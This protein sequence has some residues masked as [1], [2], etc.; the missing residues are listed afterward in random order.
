M[1]NKVTQ[2]FMASVCLLLVMTA[3]SLSWLRWGINQHPLYHQWIETQVSQSFGQDLKLSTFQVKLVGPSLELNL[4]GLTTTNGLTLDHLTLGVD[5]IGSIRSSSLLLSGVQAT[6]LAIEVK[7]Q[8]SGSW[9]PT[10]SHVSGSQTPPQLMLALATRVPSLLLDDVS[11]TLTPYQS[12]PIHIPKLDAQVHRVK[13]TGQNTSTVNLSLYSG[14][15]TKSVDDDFKVQLTLDINTHLNT[16]EPTSNVSKASIQRAQI[17]WH[18]NALEVAP[19]LS[20]MV[21]VGSSVDTQSLEI[22]GEYWLDYQTN[23]PV[24]FASKKAH[25]QLLTS[26]EKVDITGNVS[27][28]LQLG[29]SFDKTLAVTDWNMRAQALRGQVNNIDLPL[30]DLQVIKSNHQIVIQSPKLDLEKT[31]KLLSTINTLPVKVSLPMASL[32][33]SGWLREAKLQVDLTQSLEFLF[34]ANMQQVNVNAWAGVP[35]ISHADGDIWLNRYGGKV[36]I[37]DLNGLSLQLPKL[38]QRP[39]QLGGLQG[40]FNW[41]Y[42]ALA[43]RFSSSNM[44]VTLDQGHLNLLMAGTF[45][46]KGSSVEPFIQLALGM[47]DLD[48]SQLPA[49]L[50][51]TMIGEKVGAWISNAAPIGTVTEAALIYN[52]RPGKVSSTVAKMSRVLAIEAHITAPNLSYHPQWPQVKDLVVH[53]AVNHQRVLMQAQ[54]GLVTSGSESVSVAGW[55]VE[56]PISLKSNSVKNSLNSSNE[57][58]KPRFIKVQ[59]HVSGEAEKMM[60]LA[61]QLPLNIKLPSWLHSLKPEGDVSLQG[62]FGIP[63]GHQAQATYDINLTSDN[64]N[65]FWEPLQADVRQVQLEVELSSS[66]EG[67]GAIVGNGLID[68]QYISFKRLSKVELAMPWLPNIPTPILDDVASSVRGR[69]DHITLQ[70]KGRLP[71]HYL[72]TKTNQPWTQEMSGALP[73]VARVSTCM[74]APLECT[75]L[76]AQVDLTKAAITLPAPLSQLQQLQLLGYWQQG[77]QDWY[78]SIDN[79]QVAIQFGPAK[80]SNEWSVTGLNVGFDQPVDW[81]QR[82]QWNF[83]G[84]LDLV[85]MSSWWTVYQNRIKSWVD[86]QDRQNSQPRLP[87]IDVE[88]KRATWFDLD[89]NEAKVR[90]SPLD[91]MEN[92]LAINPWRLDVSSDN[93]IGYIDYFGPQEPLVINVDQAILNFPDPARQTTEIDDVLDD[94]DPTRLID[95]D[96][97]IKKIIKNG[98]PFGQWAFKIRRDSDQVYVHDLDAFIRHS[99]LQ[100][101]LI[102]Q[103]IDGIHYTQ[104]TGRAESNEMANMLMAWGYNPGLTAENSAIEVQLNWPYS[105]LAFTLKDTSGDLGLRLKKGSIS[106]SPNAAQG[107]KVLALFDVSRLIN[108]LQLDFTDIIQPGFSFDSVTAHYS[109]DKGIA[110][111]VTAS[112]FK[113]STLNLT[114][115]GWIDFKRRQVDNN[116]IITLP[117]VDKL[118]LAAL[119]AGLPQLG[120]MIYVVNKLIGDELATFTSARYHVVGSLDKP[121]VKLVRFFDKDYQ[122]QSVKERIENVISIE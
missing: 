4:T 48:L 23:G 61:E 107:L 57:K 41:H 72:T 80:V 34:T 108:R 113:A 18:S 17:Y 13:S 25:I 70:L 2:W 3:V 64:L 73:F 35:K 10:V 46:R 106:S 63:F 32:A 27:A 84:Q 55:Q 104:F 30:S 52:G 91:L 26:T 8:E 90:L 67:V 112:T 111:T 78:A 69:K 31:Q 88:L 40:E 38:I 97:T 39:W 117:V 95:A 76:S 60:I 114:M 19:W 45:P 1:M 103:K 77:Q 20:L 121:E 115:D 56:V 29:A 53:L 119:I 22:G 85:D 47:H 89:I 15:A 59:G 66:A 36:A 43:N 24:Q 109:F 102:W 105:P 79:H 28:T 51:D 49:M 94:I 71:P 74:Q 65:A 99:H 93:L 12:K 11:L 82:D 118:P 6:G 100:G 58:A 96:V 42:G 122:Q 5:L 101:N 120:G 9:G 87:S 110:S 54:S 116:L 44:V 75:S 92:P 98:E 16:N 37:K 50:P 62:D 7:Q 86:S 81:A 33:P 68:G 83:D 14:A 21:P